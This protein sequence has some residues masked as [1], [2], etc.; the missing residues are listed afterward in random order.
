MIWSNYISN[1]LLYSLISIWK[2]K[3]K[4]INDNKMFEKILDLEYEV[5]ASYL[6]TRY[7]L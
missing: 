5:I 7:K 6:V 2:T 3:M 1:T 4:N